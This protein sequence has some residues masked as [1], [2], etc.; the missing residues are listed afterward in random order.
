ME[1]KLIQKPEVLGW[2]KNLLNNTQL[3][4]WVRKFSADNL[5]DSN[6]LAEE[7]FKINTTEDSLSLADSTLTKILVTNSKFNGKELTRFNLKQLREVVDLAGTEGE[8]IIPDSDLKEM[9]VEDKNNN[10]MIVCPLPPKEKVK[11][12]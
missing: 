3:I 5:L 1:C 6:K 10:V 9:I 2:I 8:V 12:K 4:R 7:K 11:K